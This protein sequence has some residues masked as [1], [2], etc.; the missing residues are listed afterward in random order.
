MP[1]HIQPQTLK[2]GRTYRHY[3]GGLYNII[4]IAY[5]TEVKTLT[6][7]ADVD[8][9]VKMVVYRP[10]DPNSPFGNDVWWVRPYRMFVETVIIDGIEQPR[11]VEV[12]T[13]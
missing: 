12:D 4:K 3:K 6:G 9:D 2:E 13:K 5:A 10:L 7:P 1:Q 11:F 8:D